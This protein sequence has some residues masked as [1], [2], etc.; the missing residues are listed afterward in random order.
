VTAPA[1]QSTP[2]H[3]LAARRALVAAGHAGALTDDQSAELS[4]PSQCSRCGDRERYPSNGTCVT[5][6]RARAAERR[7]LK[8][9]AVI[10]AGIRAQ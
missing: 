5:C 3:V 9:P 6:S 4:L 8:G 7:A 1:P 10:R 2:R